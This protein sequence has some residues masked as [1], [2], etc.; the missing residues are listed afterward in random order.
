MRRFIAV[1]AIVLGAGM[2]LV[3]PVLS[4]FSRTSAAEKLT[5]D[6]RPAMTDSALTRTRAIENN[7]SLGTAS[8][9]RERPGNR[10]ESRPLR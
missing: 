8:P 1:T 4:L 9:S 6:I 7:A 10:P 3:P 5:D 2:M